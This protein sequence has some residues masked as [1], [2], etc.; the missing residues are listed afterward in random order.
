MTDRTAPF[1]EYADAKPLQTRTAATE[2][3]EPSHRYF[4]KRR[5]PLLLLGLLLL[6]QLWSTY[7]TVDAIPAQSRRSALL[8]ADALVIV[9][10]VAMT[11]LGT[12][13]P[14]RR[15]QKRAPERGPYASSCLPNP[16]FPPKGSMAC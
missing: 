16:P 3:A 6:A 9:I 10:G 14:R 2:D 1:A 7:A 15:F 12:R 4:V 11:L 13:A 8:V 5:R